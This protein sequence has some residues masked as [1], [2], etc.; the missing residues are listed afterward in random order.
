MPRIETSGAPGGDTLRR[1][2][3][4]RLLVGAQFFSAIWIIF[5]R[6][7]GF[8]LTEIGLAISAYHL[9]PVLLEVPAGVFADLTGR[10]PSLA[11][12]AVLVAVS[13]ALIYVAH[14]LPLVLLAMFLAGASYSF[15]SG[16]DQAY[17]YDALEVGE[18]QAGFAGIL[19][20]LLGASYL[21]TAGAAWLGA[22]LSERSY[23]WPYGLTVGAALGAVWLAVGL[24][25]PPPG[26]HGAGASASLAGHARDAWRL[27]RGRRDVA[28]MLLLSG[29]FWAAGTVAFQYVQAV[30]AERG[31]SNSA[32]GLTMGLAT[33][34][35]AI[36]LGA[37]GR[38]SRYGSL[39]QQVVLL[40]GLTGVGMVG[41][42]TGSLALV[43]SAYM[44]AN[45]ANGLIQPVLL[46][47]LNQQLPSEQRATLLSVKA[48]VTSVTIIVAFLAAG[49]L[50]GTRGWGELY[51]LT[52]GVKLG[53]GI[54]LVMVL[55]RHRVRDGGRRV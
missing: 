48:W 29:P 32:I 52:G 26:R 13:S 4:Y 39:G 38:L 2:Y 50:A 7:R 31:L 3:A 43:I 54:A 10:R 33:V 30:L 21:I 45:L 1:F 5:L 42:A 12:S 23:A 41:M 46:G 24:A 28:A 9:A 36:G 55:S 27:L 16:A 19:G 35:G 18:R 14:D 25:E 20:K 17:L 6:S 22:S 53:L 51:V 40:A 8:S 34:S 47:W 37:A 49:W 11:L 15:R 44:L